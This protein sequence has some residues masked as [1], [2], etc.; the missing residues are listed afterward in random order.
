M[1]FTYRTETRIS[2]HEPQQIGAGRL[3][4]DPTKSATARK[5]FDLFRCCL[6]PGVARWMPCHPAKKSCGYLVPFGRNA[7]TLQTDDRQTTTD[8]DRQTGLWQY[9]LIGLPAMSRQ[10]HEKRRKMSLKYT[11][12]A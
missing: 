2:K 5:R 12:K 6:V 10:K 7:R 11:F 4:Y 9:R 3:D 8:D 1:L